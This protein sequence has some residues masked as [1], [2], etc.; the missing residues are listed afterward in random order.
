MDNFNCPISQTRLRQI[1]NDACDSALATATA[2]NHAQTAAWNDSIIN[3]VLK[4]LVSE[5]QT[6]AAAGSAETTRYK[7]CVNSTIIQHLSDPRPSGT[8]STGTSTEKTAGD[9]A[10]E[11]EAEEELKKE[12]GG[13]NGESEE[14]AA[15][16]ASNKAAS[17]TGGPGRRGMHSASG[18]YWNNAKDGMWSHKYEGGEAKG[19]DIVIAIMWIA[20]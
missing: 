20:A 7:F 14:V 16:A 4:A 8:T 3:A 1:S 2:Y 5:S 12:V 19:M 18:A 10:V 15:A 9:A 11:G 6:A 13:G 17:N